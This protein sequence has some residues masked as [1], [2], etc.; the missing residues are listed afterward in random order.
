MIQKPKILQKLRWFGYFWLT[1]YNNNNNIVLNKAI[2]GEALRPMKAISWM[3]AAGRT[4]DV[5][6][7]RGGRL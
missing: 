2:S 4:G 7:R 1:G 6:V 3:Y 5:Q